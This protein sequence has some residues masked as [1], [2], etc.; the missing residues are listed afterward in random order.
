MVAAQRDIR[1]AVARWSSTR[2]CRRYVPARPGR[3]H[4]VLVVDGSHSEPP[5]SK[6]QATVV[7]IGETRDDNALRL[8]LDDGW[9]DIRPRTVR[10]RRRHDA[11]RSAGLRPPSCSL[12]SRPSGHRRHRAVG[13]R[14]VG[15]RPPRERLRV[16]LGVDAD[17]TT[18]DLDIK[19]AAEGGHGPH[20]LCVGATGSG[21][22]ELL[23]TVV[24]GMVARHSP[25]ELNLVLI[26][27]KGGA[28]F[29]GLEGL[30]HIAATITNLADEAHLVARA[31]DALA[32]EIH[33][34]QQVLRRA[35]NAVNLAA[36]RRMR[37]PGPDPATAAVAVGGRR[38]VRRTAATSSGLRRA[39]RHDRQSGSVDGGAP[40]ARQ[41]ATRRR[42]ASRPGIASLLSH[43]PQDLHRRGL[44]RGTGCSGCRRTADDTGCGIPAWRRRS[45][46]PLPDHLSRRPRTVRSTGSCRQR[47]PPSELFTSA[48]RG[49]PAVGVNGHRTVMDTLVDRFS[50]VGAPAHQVW[51]PP[52]PRSPRLSE[53]ANSERSRDD[54]RRSVS[55]TARSSSGGCRCSSSGR[56][57]WPHRG[58]RSAPERQVANGPH[59]AHRP[60]VCATTHSESS[61]TASISAAERSRRYVRCR[62]WDQ[63]PTGQITNWSAGSS[64]TSTRFCDPGRRVSPTSMATCS[65]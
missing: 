1:P 54:R 59:T 28:T 33:R 57:R 27:F 42:T 61:S 35:G 37:S 55:S 18:V 24:L 49:R 36:Y 29:L 3:C 9:L 6:A 2:G 30:H 4:L 40:A 17:G 16:P 65:W 8:H 22:S 45:A 56:R 14:R 11:V 21:K 63:W 50:G 62:T 47:S 34:R 26:D 10:P 46:A 53:L 60:G 19:E 41:S 32:G 13:R 20:G 64:A 52:L 43:L 39:V 58:G 23:R 25:D 51:L 15:P 38:R 12:P 5:L 31:N 44:T 7:V 48:P